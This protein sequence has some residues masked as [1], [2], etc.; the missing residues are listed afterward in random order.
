MADWIEP[1]Q[2]APAFTLPADDGT[3]V[4]LA[5]LRGRPVVLYFYPR[6]NS[7]GRP[8]TRLIA[9][10]RVPVARRVPFETAGRSSR[11]SAP[12]CSA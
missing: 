10:C 11:S 2:R 4:R 5:D 12:W 6:D 8:G 1:G 3:R 7:P 9:V